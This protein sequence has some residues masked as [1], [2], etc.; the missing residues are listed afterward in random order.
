[1]KEVTDKLLAEGVQL[2]ADAF[3]KL[4]KAVEKQSQEAGAGR[5][6]RL[7]YTLPEPL[8]AA[9]KG[10]LAEWRAQGKVRRLW[11]RDASLWTG[12]DEAQW[13]G[14]LGITNDQLAH[15]Q[16]LTDI[17]EAARNAGFSHVLLLGMGGSSLG[18]EVIKTTFGKISGIPGASRARFDRPGPGEGVREQGRSE[19][20][21]LHRLEQVGLDAR[22]RTSSSSISSTASNGSLARR[23]PAVVSSPS[24]IQAPR[25]SRSPKAMAFDTSSSAGR[26]SAGATRCSPISAWS[27]RPSWAWMWRS[28]W[29][30]PRR[31][32]APACRRFP[33]K[34]TPASCS[35]PSSA[36]PR[37]SSAATR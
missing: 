36:W 37:A 34:K 1:M 35:A 30:G 12:K 23:K 5:I 11:G 33:L 10:S 26:T 8:A 24:P 14:W 6:N 32:C 15:I 21:A 29:T 31:W 25:C 16:R 3:A 13:L 7:T 2:F 22:A 9:V 18:P 4:L 27:R 20:H 28:S 19:E 17:T